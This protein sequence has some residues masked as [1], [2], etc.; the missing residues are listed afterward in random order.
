MLPEEIRDAILNV[1]SNSSPEQLDEILA[2]TKAA[3]LEVKSSQ[4]SKMTPNVDDKIEQIISSIKYNLGSNVLATGN[5]ESIPTW[6]ETFVDYNSKNTINIDSF[7][8][9]EDDIDELVESGIIA[10]SYCADCNSRNIHDMNFISHSMSLHQIRWLFEVALKSYQG[11]LLDV[12]SRF[13]SVLFGAHLYS[14]FNEIIGIEIDEYFYRIAENV[15]TENMLN[16][17]LR[18]VLGDITSQQGANL[19]LNSNVIVFNNVFQFF[20][21]DN[22]R[23]KLRQ[24]WTVIRAMLTRSGTII[25]SIPSL[26]QEFSEIGCEHFMNGLVSMDIGKSN[27]ELEGFQH[28]YGL[29][30]E[31]VGDLGHVSIYKVL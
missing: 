27:A 10:R 9:Q 15:S 20:V 22:G 4:P 19:I 24:I 1:I 17:R 21:G 11:T 31:E 8:Y 2:F 3:I 30:D 12:G 14:R 7:L 25:V 18:L 5:L 26:E 6:S 23:E 16:D 28:L 13:G 29:S